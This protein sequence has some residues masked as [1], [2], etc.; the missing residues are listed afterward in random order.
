[1]ELGVLRVVVGLRLFLGVE[2]VEVAEEL[3]EAVDGGQVLVAVAQVV[4]AE[5]AAHVALFLEQVGNGRRPV[6][7]AV[8]RTRHADGEQAGAERVLAEDEGRPAGRAAL[9]G[10]GVGEQCAPLSQCG[11]CWASCNP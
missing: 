8:I 7:D 11:Q 5:L 6:G 9:L 10:V 1:M 4:L 3:V 2:V